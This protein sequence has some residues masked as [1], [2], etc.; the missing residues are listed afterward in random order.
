MTIKED[1]I[2]KTVKEIKGEKVDAL[3]E[4]TEPVEIQSALDS[5]LEIFSGISMRAFISYE[6]SSSAV[7]KREFLIRRI[8]KNKKEYYIDGLA[9]DIKAPRVIR[10]S[11]ITYITDISSK[12]TYGDPYAFLQNV[13]G[14]DVDEEYL[15][16]P[17][18]DFAK[19]INETGNELTV[20]MYLIAL[21]GNRS[22][23]ERKCVLNYVRSRVPYL[24]YSDEEMN[25]YLISLAPDDDSFAMAFHRVL[26]KGKLIIEPLFQ[27]VI[28]VITA[29][30]VVHEKER[31]FLARFIDWLKQ[32]GYQ[33]DVI[34]EK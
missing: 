3:N 11:Q 26:K 6:S 8:L 22:A 5:S 18:S 25:D 21:D 17:L 7:K 2:L 12:T 10:L 1:D 16:E 20:L 14:I 28:D 30:G 31:A 24:E 29:D 19:A 33:I 13:L 15:P 27:T 34:S 32:D 9:I 4:K 23:I